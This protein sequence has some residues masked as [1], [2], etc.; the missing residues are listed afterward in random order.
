[1]NTVYEILCNALRSENA[2]EWEFRQEEGRL[3]SLTHNVSGAQFR[4]H[5]PCILNI[6][7]PVH[8]DGYI[9]KTFSPREGRKLYKRAVQML[10]VKLREA[11]KFEA[12]EEKVVIEDNKKALM[13]KF[14]GI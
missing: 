11:A 9:L 8:K 10:K 4:V 5:A 7:S 13:K 2:D 12:E 3:M 6:L 1:M 14:L